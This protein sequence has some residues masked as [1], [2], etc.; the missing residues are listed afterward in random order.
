MNLFEMYGMESEA[1]AALEKK[2]AKE[3]K[4]AEKNPPSKKG[5]SNSYALP[6][7]AITGYREPFVLEGNGEIALPDIKKSLAKRLEISEKLLDVVV[8]NGKA[9][10]A[11]SKKNYLKKGQVHVKS[12]TV[13]VLPTG[14]AGPD[15]SS[16]LDSG[17]QDIELED[18][19]EFLAESDPAYKPGIAL[20]PDNN[21]LH[22][23]PDG[24]IKGK[25]S[26][27]F[28]I[29]L[30]GRET[31][32]L[33]KEEYFSFAEKLKKE[34]TG[35][36]Q[37]IVK[38]YIVSKYPEYKGHLDIA[39]SESDITAIFSANLPP[40]K[41]E[42]ETYPTDAKLYLMSS[43]PI[44]LSADMFDGEEV[45]TQDELMRYVRENVSPIFKKERCD[46]QYFDKEKFI[47]ITM[48]GSK[49]GA[50]TVEKNQVD[51]KLE[52]E[53]ALIQY[54]DGGSKIIIEKNPSV[55]AV[56]F[57]ERQEGTMSLI[58]G[59][60]PDILFFEIDM[61]FQEIAVHYKTEALV[62]I[63]W[64]E[65]EGYQIVVPK[66]SVTSSSVE[67]SPLWDARAKDIVVAEIHSHCHYPAF[68]SDTD[69]RD[70]AMA[71]IYG[72]IGGYGGERT[73]RFRTFADGNEIPLSQEDIFESMQTCEPCM[74]N[75][76]R[77]LEAFKQNI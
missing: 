2:K 12:P 65:R 20:V 61:L 69:N 14:D 76:S 50:L 58:H 41:Q 46:I 34:G 43:T 59:K 30:I 21:I 72:V 31:L 42:E 16:I 60:I 7:E 35:F 62:R 51:K 71:L 9:Y 5:K 4:S 37:E 24:E 77:H 29:H 22:V 68:W 6:L 64:N 33:K 10:A 11:L 28:K 17:K 66:Q 47:Y 44:Q 32:L 52:Q 23:V 75:A 40:A 1:K 26:F 57:E 25:H 48:K 54:Y 73:R 74:G 39:A 36:N 56:F 8:E 63:V 3:K 18:I 67:A 49:K 27:P 13:L 38:E 15:L 53:Y 70:E 19:K 55:K 45:V